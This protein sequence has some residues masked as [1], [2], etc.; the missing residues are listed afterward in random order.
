MFARLDVLCITK[1]LYVLVFRLNVILKYFAF[2][3]VCVGICWY[4]PLMFLKHK[5]EHCMQ[6]ISCFFFIYVNMSN[7]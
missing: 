3:I 2:V 5:E 7:I 6:K 1:L 4:V